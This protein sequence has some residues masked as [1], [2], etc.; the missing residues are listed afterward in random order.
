MACQW[1]AVRVGI[2]SIPLVHLTNFDVGG[3]VHR[4][5]DI[6]GLCSA[7]KGIGAL[8][9]VHI[10]VLSSVI[11]SVL[12]TVLFLPLDSI[13][14]LMIVWKMTGKIIRTTITITYAQL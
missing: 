1:F 9:L 10:H 5:V 12:V 14:W 2:Q 7:S 8:D 11:S 4:G 3:V 6:G 13:M